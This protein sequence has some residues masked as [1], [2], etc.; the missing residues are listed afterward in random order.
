MKAEVLIY[1]TYQSQFSLVVKNVL[2][3]LAFSVYGILM[4][5]ACFAL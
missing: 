5:S 1:H 2:L 3:L 4:M